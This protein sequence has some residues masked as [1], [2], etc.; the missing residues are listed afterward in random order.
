MGQAAVWS[1]SESCVAASWSATRQR[2]HTTA[3]P[4]LWFEHVVHIA[5]PRHRH[6]QRPTPL[7]LDQHDLHTLSAATFT[8]IQAVIVGANQ[9]DRTKEG[10]R[11]P[12]CAFCGRERSSMRGSSHLNVAANPQCRLHSMLREGRHRTSAFG[13]I[14]SRCLQETRH[15]SPEDTPL[16]RPAS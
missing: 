13:M 8:G 5:S 15:R 6:Q 1:Q 4:V 10:V 7:D 2:R 16:L 9:T 14:E 12:V 11:R 3:R